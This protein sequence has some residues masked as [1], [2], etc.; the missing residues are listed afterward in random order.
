M[1]RCDRSGRVE[2]ISRV[3]RT[4][5]RRSLNRLVRLLI[6]CNLKLCNLI[7]FAVNPH[8]QAS[9][10]RPA[11]RGTL[12]ESGA[13]FVIGVMKAVAGNNEGLIFVASVRPR[14]ELLHCTF[15][16]RAAAAPQIGSEPEVVARCQCERP[17]SPKDR[18]TDEDCRKPTFHPRRRS[19]EDASPDKKRQC[20]ADD[21]EDE[22]KR[23]EPPLA[24]A[25][26]CNIEDGD[27][28]PSIGGGL[29]QR[30]GYGNFH[31]T[32]SIGEPTDNPEEQNEL[33]RP[34]SIPPGERLMIGQTSFSV[35]GPFLPV[36]D[37]RA[38]A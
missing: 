37:Q 19:A 33:N 38:S 15:D 20:N 35:R 10:N 7:S 31:S 4:A 9:P 18:E 3:D 27:V 1:A 14:V 36:W 12:V 24:I 34:K 13:D 25:A 26:L 11:V 21:N 5:V 2:V 6:L 16:D 29:R 22:A 8:L 32:R 28:I 30:T 17:E 23:R